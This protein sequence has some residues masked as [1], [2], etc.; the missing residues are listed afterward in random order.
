M[1]QTTL[2]QWDDI[3]TDIIERNDLGHA[4][5]KLLVIA[6]QNLNKLKKLY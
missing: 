6:Y 4:I 3:M 2:R 1:D 5:N